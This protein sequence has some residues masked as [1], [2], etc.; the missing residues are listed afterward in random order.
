M[1][2]NCT[3]ID[4]IVSKSLL[5]RAER[6]GSPYWPPGHRWIAALSN[7]LLLF[8]MF[9]VL[10]LMTSKSWDKHP[11]HG[12][13]YSQTAPGDHLVLPCCQSS[14]LLFFEMSPKNLMPNVAWSLSHADIQRW[15]FNVH[16]KA[17]YGTITC[18]CFC[19]SAWIRSNH[20][21]TISSL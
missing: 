14:Q 13:Y 18:H 11:K 3:A 21:A 1:G 10:A 8:L 6:R 19:F 12:E 9:A 5:E 2:L 15:T 16:L 7:P 20:M 4:C 17:G